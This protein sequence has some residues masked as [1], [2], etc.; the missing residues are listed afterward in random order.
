MHHYVRNSIHVHQLGHHLVRPFASSFAFLRFGAGGTVHGLDV[1]LYCLTMAFKYLHARAAAL[2]VF[3]RSSGWFLAATARVSLALL[4]AT[5]WVP[6]QVQVHW[7]RY[8]GLAPIFGRG[9]W[10]GVG[11]F[12]C[13][14]H[15]SKKYVY[16][17]QG[18]SGWQRPLST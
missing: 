1:V 11:N 13:N 7:E 17:R 15:P 10:S 16:A 3:G 4:L 18:Q 5:V 9:K 6:Y 12:G 2:L 8:I 14:R